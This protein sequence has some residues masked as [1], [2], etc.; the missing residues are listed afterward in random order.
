MVLP[1]PLLSHGASTPY[2]TARPCEFSPKV[3]PMGSYVHRYG[4]YAEPHDVTTT[5]NRVFTRYL[6]AKSTQNVSVFE[7]LVERLMK[8]IRTASV[9]VF[10][11]FN[12]PKADMDE[13]SRE[14]AAG[15][16]D[17]LDGLMSI[18][19][20]NRAMSAFL[21]RYEAKLRNLRKMLQAYIGKSTWAEMEPIIKAQGTKAKMP[22]EKL[23][24][25]TDLLLGI[26]KS[27]DIEAEGTLRYAGFNVA[28]MNTARGAEWDDDRIVLLKHV[29]DTSVRSL[30]RIGFG[31][32]AYG[33]IM[34]FP[35]NKLPA[36]AGSGHNAFASYRMSSDDMRVSIDSSS[37]KDTVHAMV[38]ELGHRVYFRLLG[39]QARSA[40]REFFDAMQGA[41]DVDSIIAAWE[42]YA[43]GTETVEGD[44]DGYFASKYGA[45]SPYFA[46][47][48]RKTGQTE[49]LMWLE[50]IAK[51]IGLKED[52][53]P[54]TG[55]PRRKKD[56]V[57]GLEQLKAKKG[58]V[59]AFMYPITAYSATHADE[60]FAE[61]VAA[62]ALEGPG[63]IPE[64]V[65]TEFKRAIPQV[66]VAGER[67]PLKF[68]STEVL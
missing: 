25:Y 11:P 20:E 15:A 46:A 7:K 19:S 67:D 6:H 49:M 44:L 4:F 40:W 37:V 8:P 38:H 41:P 3:Q 68:Q 27:S 62:L 36:G 14:I 30:A 23:R 61:I 43:T 22:M 51:K 47:H 21:K 9:Y 50:I 55:S 32:V 59:K 60:L 18:E 2:P 53:D 48:L 10:I 13:V 57:P 28:L 35:T 52:L 26:L 31:G 56:N 58:E 5:T 63:R 12:R 66:K 45:W 33:T 17:L 54:M 42:R 29:L 16:R 65:L 64:I 39:G 34:A 24:E 1:Q